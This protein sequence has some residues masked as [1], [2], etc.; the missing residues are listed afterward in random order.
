MTPPQFPVGPF[1]PEPAQTPERRAE[2]IAQL[3]SAPATLRA[4]V[5]GLS[6]SQLD[7]LYKNWT[8]RQIVHHLADSH[9]NS[10]VRFKWTLTESQPTIKAYHEG[11][12]AALVDSRTGDIAAPLALFDAL[13]LRWVLLLRMMTAEQFSR[14]FVHPETNEVISLNVALSYYAWHAKHHTA[15]I[16][17]L[18]DQR[19]W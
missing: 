7:T 9:I 10:Y 17:W 1:Q 18:R 15:Q 2:L 4:T 16:R 8:I 5:S 6:E 14:A 13:H 12:W 11:D 19:G 3:A